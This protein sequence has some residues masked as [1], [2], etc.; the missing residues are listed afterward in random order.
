MTLAPVLHTPD[1]SC[2]TSAPT[3]HSPAPA[4]RSPTSHMPSPSLCPPRFSSTLPSPSLLQTCSHTHCAAAASPCGRLPGAP[5]CVMPTQPP[6][7][8]APTSIGLRQHRV[9]LHEEAPILRIPAG[10]HHYHH[11]HGG[12]WQPQTC[13]TT[14][15]CRTASSRMASWSTYHCGALV[16]PYVF[17]TSV[18]HV[19]FG[20][21]TLFDTTRQMPWP[22]F[23]IKTKMTILYTDD[24]HSNSS[25]IHM[26]GNTASSSGSGTSQ[27]TDDDIV[28]AIFSAHSHDFIV[29]LRKTE[30]QPRC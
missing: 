10:V 4:S 28:D 17:N 8:M 21:A 19:Y 22:I 25:R 30:K 29:V 6:S 15:I 7:P 16:H 5:S 11:V 1:V 18:H 2:S 13:S 14:N 26:R 9:P 12:M 3:P 23:E 20:P 27:H 24:S